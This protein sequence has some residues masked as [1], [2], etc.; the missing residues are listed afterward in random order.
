MSSAMAGAG[1]NSTAVLLSDDLEIYSLP[2]FADY[3]PGQLV[4]SSSGLLSGRWSRQAFEKAPGTGS[5]VV[6]DLL[7]PCQDPQLDYREAVLLPELESVDGF[8]PSLSAGGLLSR[9]GVG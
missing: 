2:Q 7:P 6:V 9:R 4:P 3:T 8:S 1:G 5:G